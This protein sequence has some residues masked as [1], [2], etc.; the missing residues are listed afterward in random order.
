MGQFWEVL[1]KIIDK[2]LSILGSDL[3]QGL[4][5]AFTAYLDKCS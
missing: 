4:N 3:Y 5:A 2:T 1:E